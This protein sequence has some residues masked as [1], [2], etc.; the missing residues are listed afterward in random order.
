MATLVVQ[1]S[2]RALEMKELQ[3]L[4]GASSIELVRHG[5]EFEFHVEQSFRKAKRFVLDTRLSRERASLTHPADNLSRSSLYNRLRKREITYRKIQDISSKE[6][7]EHV[8]SR[9][10]IYEGMDY[11]VRYYDAV[12][13]PPIPVLNILSVDNEY[14]YLGRFY[15]GDAPADTENLAYIKDTQLGRLL[16]TYWNNLWLCAKPLNERKRIDWEELRL[17]GHRLGLSDE[18]FDALVDT[19]KAEIQRRKTK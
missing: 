14:F 9:L 2:R 16:E 1:T 19:W 5:R 10:L 17:I 11:F 12:G 15:T 13:R 18:D 7:L 8:I 3:N 4:V 6:R